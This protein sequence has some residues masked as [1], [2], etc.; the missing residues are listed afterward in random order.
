MLASGTA[1]MTTCGM[2]TIEGLTMATVPETMTA[3]YMVIVG[4]EQTVA[5]VVVVGKIETHI[6]DSRI[7]GA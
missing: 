7:A 2:G 5:V 4:G 1:I 6:L 3:T